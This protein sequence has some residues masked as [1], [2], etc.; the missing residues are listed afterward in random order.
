ME[1]AMNDGYVDNETSAVLSALR[2]I[3]R[4]IATE[5]VHK[6]N[7][8]TKQKADDDHREQA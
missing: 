4:M 8:R 7:D 5:S 1:S 2:P 6:A 3:E